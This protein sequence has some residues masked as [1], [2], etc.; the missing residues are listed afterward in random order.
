MSRPALPLYA[1][2]GP[3]SGLFEAARA[4]GPLFP[5]APPGQETRMSA[6]ECLGF[7][8]GD[9]QPGEPR[10]EQRWDAD[11]VEG[12]EVSW[13]LGYGPR[14]QAWVLKPKGARRPLPGIVA[15]HDHG[16]FKFYGKEKIADGPEGRLAPLAPLRHTFYGGRAYANELARAGFVVL[17]PD[18][19]LFGSRK[20]P[21]EAMP[22]NDRAL[23]PAVE[24]ALG[25]DVVA[26][27][28]YNGA[29]YAHE[30]VVAKYCTVLGTSL[31]AVVAHEDRVAL[32]YF[33]ARPDVAATRVASIGLSGGGLR[34]ALL[35]ATSD[36]LGAC[37]IVGMMSTYEGLLDG[38][39]ATHTW[40]LFPPSWS[41]RGDWPDLAASAAPAPLL[42]QY[43]LDDPLFTVAGMRAADARI[44][45][46]YRSV[47]APDAYRGE[48]H[49]G[50]HRFDVPMQQNAISWLRERLGA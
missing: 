10:V 17:V 8:V 38:C 41:R 2:L 5:N 35:R 40:M 4:D 32:A 1:H 19:F 6:R 30:H 7:R 49:P 36:D 37:A 21:L 16:H 3:F 43:A 46:C 27:D 34:S 48:F 33:R 12:E 22:D 18:A 9:E 25:P 23:A 44:A 13:S 20:F 42:V 11:G 39:V 45:G 31:A 15:L 26:P 29:A 14:S 28:H 24:A 50:G 47:G